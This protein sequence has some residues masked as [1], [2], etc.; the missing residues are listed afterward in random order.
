MVG[1]IRAGGGVAGAAVGT[2]VGRNVGATVV[3]DGGTSMGATLG[4]IV[5]TTAAGGA[6]GV[7]VGNFLLTRLGVGV[8]GG[9]ENGDKVG[10]TT[11]TGATVGARVAA[12]RFVGLD[13]VVGL[14]V[15]RAVTGGPAG[16]AGA[17]DGWSV[18]TEEAASVSFL[19]IE[20]EITTAAAAATASATMASD[21]SK[22][23]RRVERFFFRSAA[24]IAARVTL[25]VLP[26]GNV[27]MNDA[28]GYG[29]NLWEQGQVAATRRDRVVYGS[30]VAP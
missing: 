30:S 10:S 25:L 3:S 22:Q 20:R 9:S 26:D 14:R 12:G 15:G 28:C 11:L 7:A 4:R 8:C 1:A 6:D 18:G 19:S 24:R 21:H 27:M 5:G 2:S 17:F 16:A 29:G 23:V 13:L